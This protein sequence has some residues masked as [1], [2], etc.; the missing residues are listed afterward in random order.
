[1]NKRIILEVLAE[2][3]EEITLKCQT[4]SL[5]Q[6]ARKLHCNRITLISQTESHEEIINGNLIHVRSVI[7]W[8]F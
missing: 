6:A 7:D 8:L 3:K 2:Q 4:E 5:S 1:M